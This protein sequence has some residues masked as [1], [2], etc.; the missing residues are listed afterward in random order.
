[1]LE[2]LKSGA[3]KLGISLSPRQLEQFE[4]YYKEMVARNEQ[5]NLTA[6]TEYNDVQIKH[7]LD[8][9]T[10]APVLVQGKQIRLIDVGSGAGFPGIPLKI[11]SPAIQLALL[12]ATGKKARFLSSMVDKLGMAGVSVLNQRAEDAA[13]QPQYRDKFDVVVA[14]GLAPMAVLAE[15]TLPLCRV[16]GIV[17]AQKKGDISAEIEASKAAISLLGGE[18]REPRKI[19]LSELADNRWLIIIDK[20]RPTPEKF[21]RRPGM[22]AKTPLA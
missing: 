5:I 22:P 9:L 13:R 15:L 20:K 18:L 17:I 12:E 14:R 4:L 11:W 16:G 2:L 6:I 1:M 8:S 21:P 19:E 7:F 3:E 10:I